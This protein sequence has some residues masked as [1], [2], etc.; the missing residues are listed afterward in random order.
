[1][2]TTLFQDIVK[3]LSLVF[4]DLLER[5][6]LRKLHPV[7]LNKRPCL[8][9]IS[10]NLAWSLCLKEKHLNTSHNNSYIFYL[11]LSLFISLFFNKNFILALEIIHIVN[12]SYRLLKKKKRKKKKA[13]SVL[14]LTQCSSNWQMPLKIISTNSSPER[15]SPEL[16]VDAGPALL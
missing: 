10:E 12:L 6:S 3:L 1:M 13:P 16:K 2:I 8:L 4:T 7:L 14:C 5:P 15:E 11:Y 9:F